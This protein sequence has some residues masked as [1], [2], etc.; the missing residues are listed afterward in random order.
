MK[1]TVKP[2]DLKYVNQT[3]PMVKHFIEESVNRGVSPEAS[4]YTPDQ[5]MVYLTT[6]QWIL[7]VAVDEHNKLHGAMTMSFINYPKDRIGFVT[8]TGGKAIVNKDV[9]KQLSI[10]AKQYGATKIQ[11]MARP[12]MVRL[13]ETCDFKKQNTLMEIQL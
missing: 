11:A 3:W 10:I 5:I 4:N 12:A 8:A 2:V 13:L 9:F 7:L 1:L 6:G